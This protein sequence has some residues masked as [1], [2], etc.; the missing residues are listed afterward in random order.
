MLVGTNGTPLA[1]REF[2]L[3]GGGSVVSEL[4]EYDEDRHWFRYRILKTTL[5]LA[6]YVGEMWV[7]PAD[8]GHATV[9]WSAQFQRP[10]GSTDPDA[11]DRA[12]EGLVQA[13]FTAG[14]D[15]LHLLANG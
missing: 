5:P 3:K 2:D 13:V 7:E 10:V 4:L 6:N 11:D 1:V 9:R 15:N 8:D 14:L 12:T